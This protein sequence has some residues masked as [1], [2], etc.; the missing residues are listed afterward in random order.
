[1]G[2]YG[3]V[4]P[5]GSKTYGGYATYN[6]SPSH[7]VFKIPDAIPSA[8]AAPMLC[9]GITVYSPLKAEGCGPGKTACSGVIYYRARSLRGNC[10]YR[11][12]EAYL[13]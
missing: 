11:S 6:R 4:Y 2:T 10:M 9:A 13:L 12:F 1:M 7:F 3:S 5:D 8:H